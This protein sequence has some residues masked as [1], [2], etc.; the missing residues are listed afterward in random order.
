MWA[1]DKPNLDM[2]LRRTFPIY[3]EWN[4]AFG[5]DMTN[6]FNHVIYNGPSSAT[7]QSGT[8]ASFGTISTLSSY[9]RD[10]QAS[11]RISW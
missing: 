3:R 1:Q 5:V 6:L 8:N 11:L 9:P 7:V 4:A 2:S 10:L